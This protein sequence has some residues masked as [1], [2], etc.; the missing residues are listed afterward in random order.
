MGSPLAVVNFAGENPRQ[1]ARLLPNS[2]AQLASNCKLTSGELE[3][4]RG[5]DFTFTL[6]KWSAGDPVVSVHRVER[7]GADYW[8]HWVRSELLQTEVVK[9]FPS[10]TVGDTFDRLYYNKG[11]KLYITTKS[12]ATIGAG[13]DYPLAS[14]ELGVAAP[15]D[16][17][18]V[19]A[20]QAATETQTYAYAYYDSNA[21]QLCT[22]ISPAGSAT[23]YPLANGDWR[24][25]MEASPD[26][27]LG[28][29]LVYPDKR[30]VYRNDAGTFKQIAEVSIDTLTVTDTNIAFGAAFV[31]GTNPYNPVAPPT[32]T[33]AVNP[34]DDVTIAYV[35]TFVT[36]Y[37]EES[38]PSPSQDEPASGQPVSPTYPWAITMAAAP[39]VGA[40]A[41]LQYRRI[42]RTFTAS[43]GSTAFQFV[44]EIDS[45]LTSFND[46][47]TD[48]ALG[49]ALTSETWEMPPT[50]IS[51]FTYMGNGVFAVMAGK[52]LYFSEP[53]Q[54]HA[55]PSQYKRAIG[56]DGVALEAIG[57]SLIVLTTGDPV[58]YTG[59]DPSFLSDAKLDT[60]Q[61][62]VS[63]ATVVNT[64]ASVAYMSPVGYV[65]ASLGGSNVI[66][67]QLFA[68][69]D[70]QRINSS[71]ASIATRYDD[72]LI[73][74]TPSHQYLL[75]P[76]E[77]LSTIS[78]LNITEVNA[79]YTDPETGEV[80]YARNGELYRW[81]SFTTKLSYLWRSKVFVT[82]RQVNPGV[83]KIESD[84]GADSPGNTVDVP[85][86]LGINES[87][88]N[89]A[90]LP[91]LTT[92]PIL[93]F[94]LY[95][96]DEDSE[97]FV[98]RHTEVVTSSA[99]FTLP[100]GYKSDSFYFELE[101][102]ATVKT[103]YLAETRAQ[104]KQIGA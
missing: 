57:N 75:T 52:T 24:V 5:P 56:F 45:A 67:R 98:L 58:V 36:I 20:A 43:D 76:S 63:A 95:A 39:G 22:T 28:Q 14:Y 54:P 46:T 94:R 23:G 83:C 3:P 60:N 91:Y 85:G 93:T 69:D 16:S 44:A 55:F 84:A 25:T 92:D 102:T 68:K 13:T 80:Y 64:G 38:A 17:P 90:P 53:F 88:I 97:A 62:C 51:G 15:T 40:F 35:Y 37:G 66:T 87:G 11:G 77:P 49:E 7:N 19:T 9:L 82:P 2:M 96:W 33:P 48:A 101:G 59:T 61:P 50:G 18:G 81:D 78:S 103:V 74:F 47:V 73:F 4:W 41:P 71:T 21:G 12:L 1:S 42:Y 8:F 89:G 79:L 30:R 26:V 6:S 10:P 32:V 104:L 70:W 99:D 29:E 86:G 34:V 100:S 27:I 31:A 72:G 65:F